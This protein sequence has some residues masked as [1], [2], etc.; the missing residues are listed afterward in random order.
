MLRNIVWTVF[1]VGWLLVPVFE[2]ATGL[3]SLAIFRANALADGP[4]RFHYPGPSIDDDFGGAS[5]SVAVV[6]AEGMA[7]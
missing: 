1:G 7:S 2:L 3:S 6:R 5:P 4:V